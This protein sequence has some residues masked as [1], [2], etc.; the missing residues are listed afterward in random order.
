MKTAH[1][2]TFPQLHYWAS[3]LLAL[4]LIPLLRH[5]NIPFAFDWRT[6]GTAWIL[7][8]PQSI[9]LATLLYVIGFPPQESWQPAWHRLREHPL[10]LILI[11]AFFMVAVWAAGWVT[12]VILIVDAISLLEFRERLKPEAAREAVNLLA[13]AFYLFAGFLLVF[14]YNDIILSQRFFA[15]TDAA[16]NSMDR[17]LLHGITVPEVCHWAVRTFPASFFHV[18]EW[19]YFGMFLHIGA[20]II[21]CT[22]YYGRRRGLQFVGTILV[23]YYLALA[24]FYLWPSQGP[25][26]LCPTHFSDFPSD[27]LAY[28]IQKQSLANSSGIWN[29]VRLRYISTDYYIA[30]PCMHI[31]QPLIVMWFLRRWK[32]MLMVLAAYDLLLCVAIVLLEWHYIVDILAGGLVAALAI[33]LVDGRIS[34]QWSEKRA[35]AESA[36]S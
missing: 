33:I 27:L 25:F 6:F 1:V 5:Y 17:W 15:A 34:W 22:V 19:I 30:F 18:L 20:A 21:L 31:V 16:F 13:P 32:R 3:A 29:H 12:A 9:F 24:L 8:A 23:A 2:Q 26:Y 28:E 10:R 36:F 35:T 14:A 7:L 11:A 4:A